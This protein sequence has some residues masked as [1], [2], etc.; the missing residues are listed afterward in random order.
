MRAG[1]PLKRRT[2][3]QRR[4]ELNNG[5]ELDRGTGLRQQ[6]KK[7]QAENR[8][9]RTVV[10]VTFGDQPMCAA[11][12]CTRLADDIHEPLTRARGGSI[13]DPTNMAPLCRP[14]HTEI[15]DEQPEWA[16][17]VGLLV[18]SWDRGDA[19]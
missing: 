6:S 7:R 2:R 3:L 12:D 1:K 17:E 8:K 18:H 9:R 13:T 10:R 16:Y 4:A 15:T 19:A 14:C 5:S 11:P